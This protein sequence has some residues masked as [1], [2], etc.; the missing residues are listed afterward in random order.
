MK[1]PDWEVIQTE[2][3]LIFDSFELGNSLFIK[4]IIC[5]LLKNSRYYRYKLIKSFRYFNF[6][7]KLPRHYLKKLYWGRKY[8]KYSLLTNCQINC[9]S[10]GEG[11]YIEHTPVAINKFCIIGK[12]LRLVGNNCI[13][14]GRGGVPKIGN[15]VS[16]GYGAIVI[17]DV[18]IADN[19][20]IGAGA[21]VTRSITKEGAIVVGVNQ[22]LPQKVK[23]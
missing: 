4:K 9:D 10:I 7:Q 20:T 13:G 17:G 3:Y 21:I 12:N 6:Y 1:F 19:V 16:M 14:G 18:T 2:A 5:W 22:L 8:G 11:L 23:R 15:N